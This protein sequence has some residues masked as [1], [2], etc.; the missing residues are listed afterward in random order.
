MSAT[1]AC[2]R[3]HTWA[4]RT[5]KQTVGD[6]PALTFP[7][8]PWPRWAD[9]L[10]TPGLPQPPLL[11]HTACQQSEV[12]GDLINPAVACSHSGFLF[13]FLSRP[14]APCRSTV[15]GCERPPSSPSAHHWDLHRSIALPIKAASSGGDSESRGQ[16]RPGDLGGDGDPRTA[17]Q[18]PAA[19]GLGTPAFPSKSVYAP[20]RL[21]VSFQSVSNGGFGRFS[22]DPQLLFKREDFTPPRSIT[23]TG[24][25]ESQLFGLQ[26]FKL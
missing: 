17:P 6:P 1:P 16:G 14:P 8:A 19:L 23:E 10:G 3:T 18:T 15:S 7:R 9:V 2:C 11:V 4:G 12:Y 5:H 21:S 13:T 22:P 26:N 24:D 25:L 20:C